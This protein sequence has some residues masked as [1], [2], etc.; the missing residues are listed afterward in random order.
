[1]ALKDWKRSKSGE[2]KSYPIVYRKRIDGDDT[3]VIKYYKLFKQYEVQ[4][5]DIAF[6]HSKTKLIALQKLKSYMKE[7]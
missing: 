6:F 1:M 2:S 7:H 3:L 4:R 5:N